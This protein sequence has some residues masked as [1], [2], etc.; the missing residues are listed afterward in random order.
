MKDM[1]HI[2]NIAFS[3]SNGQMF[4]AAKHE[5][6][7]IQFVFVFQRASGLF[8]HHNMYKILAHCNPLHLDPRSV[9]LSPELVQLNCPAMAVVAFG[10]IYYISK[11]Q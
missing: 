4:L 11:N 8:T 5:L 9:T 1:L 7:F 10:S 3:I 6:Q 2:F